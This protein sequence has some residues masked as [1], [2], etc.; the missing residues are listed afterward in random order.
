MRIS[1]RLQSTATV[2]LPWRV[3]AR[4]QHR[5]WGAL[6]PPPPPAGMSMSKT[7]LCSN[8]FDSRHG[9]WR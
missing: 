3:Q 9:D 1:E 6:P 7:R 4:S 5:A 8:R 2:L